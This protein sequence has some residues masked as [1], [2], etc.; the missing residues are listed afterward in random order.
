[1]SP[2]FSL[3]DKNKEENIMTIASIFRGL[4]SAREIEE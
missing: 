1:M 3:T 2:E 4:V